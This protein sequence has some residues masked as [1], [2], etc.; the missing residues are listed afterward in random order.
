MTEG[1]DTEVGR[2]LTTL[3]LATRGDDGSLV[4]DGAATDTMIV[5][6]GDNGTYGLSVKA[7]FDPTRAK[8]YAYQTGVW[9]PLIASGPLVNAKNV[10]TEESSMV[11]GVDLYRLFAEVA[12]VKLDQVV[13]KPHTID[14]QPMLPYLKKTKKSE[15]RDTNFTQV[16]QNIHAA[17]TTLWPC[18]IESVN[19]CVQLFTFEG[20]CNDEGGTW[21]GPD[22]AAGTDGLANCCDVNATTGENYSLFPSSQWA[23]RDDDYKI[24]LTEQ[25]NCATS[26]LDLAYEFYAIDDVAPNPE[27]DRADANLL[28]SPDLPPQGLDSTQLKAFNALSKKLDKMLESQP[29]CSGDGNLDARVNEKDFDDWANFAG[30]GSSRYDLNFDG[31]TDDADT[32]LIRENFGAR[33]A[34]KKSPH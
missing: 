2:L 8:G 26:Q 16:G 28:T 23:I 20:L 7:P 12:G 29:P 25:Q 33:C 17:G 31:Q 10:G 4:Y 21:Y 19:I 30:L 15:I 22:G 32:M 18:V 14:A 1:L 9:V 5:I 11:N 13:P 24:V 34:V 3:G 27:L 6:I